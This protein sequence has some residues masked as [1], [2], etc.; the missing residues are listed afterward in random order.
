MIRR[1]Q[2]AR[3]A[4]QQPQQHAPLSHMLYMRPTRS[5]L[6]TCARS[7]VCV[8]KARQARLDE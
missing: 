3:R 1:A 8:I 2:Y 5:A 4:L 6:H 7:Q